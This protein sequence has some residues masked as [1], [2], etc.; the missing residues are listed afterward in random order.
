MTNDMIMGYT[1]RHFVMVNT[2]FRIRDVATET[3]HGLSQALHGF[4]MMYLKMEHNCSLPNLGWTADCCGWFLV[5]FLSVRHRL[6]NIF[7]AAQPLK[8]K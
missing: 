4:A 8:L 1:K 7:D 5:N 6:P 3:F 2:V